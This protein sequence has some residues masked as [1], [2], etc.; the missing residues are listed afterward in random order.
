MAWAM[1]SPLTPPGHKLIGMRGVI[2][3]PNWFGRVILKTFRLVDGV[4]GA[5]HFLRE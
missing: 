2:T 5:L 1:T 3:N 4:E